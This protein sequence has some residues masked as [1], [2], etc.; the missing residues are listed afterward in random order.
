MTEVTQPATPDSVPSNPPPIDE[1]ARALA[2]EIVEGHYEAATGSHM[3]WL[4][5]ELSKMLHRD[6][7]LR[8]REEA[9][10]KVGRHNGAPRDRQ[11]S[12]R[13]N[14]RGGQSSSG[15]KI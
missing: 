12:R 6:F 2:M 14:G 13:S 9:V 11:H 5:R 3:H 8:A 15:G 7:A 10:L 1:R 4:Y